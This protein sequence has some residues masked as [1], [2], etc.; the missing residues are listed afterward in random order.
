MPYAVEL[1]LDD[2][3]A[4]IVRA[5]WREIAAAGAPSMADSGAN[6][7]VS[8]MIWDDIEREAML[9]ALTRFGAETPAIDV[10][11]PRVE[12]FPSS[13]VVFL[14]PVADAGLLDAH[15]R[16]HRTFAGLG[17]G[18]WPHYD[19]GAWAPHCTLAMDLET[20]MDRIVSVAQRA[21]LPLRGRLV[22]VELVEFRPVR[23]LAF[24]PLA[25]GP[26]A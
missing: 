24:A 8:L 16:C 15:A 20:E 17:R 9:S 11:F 25:A 14:A 22:R 1:A 26:R 21:P 19:H 12:T 7:H 2:E 10:V 3:A 18:A 23:R 6:P 4:G 5:L 13:G